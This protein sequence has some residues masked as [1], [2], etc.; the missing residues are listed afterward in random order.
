LLFGA[1]F[2]ATDPVGAPI[3]PNGRIIFG[4]FIGFLVVMLRVFSSYPESVM[5]AILFGNAISPSINRL[6]KLKPYGTKGGSK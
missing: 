3:M 2:M 4:L 1:V 5:Y 6:T